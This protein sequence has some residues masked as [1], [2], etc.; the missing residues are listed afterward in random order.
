MKKI[1]AGLLA[2]SM[3]ATAMAGCSNGSSDKK[4]DAGQSAVESKADESS[5][6][7][8][9]AAGS[10]GF[11][12]RSDISYVMI[13]NPAVYNEKLDNNTKTPSGDMK[14]VNPQMKRAGSVEEQEEPL[15]VAQNGLDK[16]VGDT[17]DADFSADRA[18]FIAP[19]YKKGEK[20]SFFYC[21]DF[22][23]GYLYKGEFTCEYVG[24]KCYVWML[25]K[26]NSDKSLAESIAK[27]FDSTIYDKDVALF[28]EPRYADKGG[29]IHLMFHDIGKNIGGYFCQTDIFSTDEMSEAVAESK[30]F[31]LNH[32]MVHINTSYLSAANIRTINATIAHEFQHLINAS[33]MFELGKRLETDTWLNEAMSGYAE[34]KLYPGIQK[35]DG[36]YEYLAN[37]DLLRNG[38][39]LF[40]F[41][42]DMTPFSVDAGVY[43]SV[44]LFSM[45]MENLAGEDVFRN[46]HNY[47]RTSFSPTL[48]TAEALYHAVPETVASDIDGKYSYPAELNFKTE[49]EKWMSKLALDFYMSMLKYDSNDPEAFKDVDV[50][51]L[52][53]DQVNP[54]QIEGGGRVIAAT[55]DGTFTIPEDAGKPLVYIG[56]D[57]DFNPVTDI[58]YK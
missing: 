9:P 10:G 54:A 17:S 12:G 43:G 16:L 23:A 40:N 51:T 21:P 35:E 8:A 47:W 36:R 33:D 46:L 53:Y 27:E 2:V 18:G 25:S 14:W 11:E 26:E 42:T 48:S 30:G 24:E 29:K 57:K 19:T 28:G 50:Q 5:K 1:L 3:L 58:I 44:F 38:Q 20:H 31:N 39:S 4:D 32:A 34:E 41:A 49:D 55:K 15:T 6:E 7:A 45:Y 52:L 37:S 22:S 56:F 13:Y